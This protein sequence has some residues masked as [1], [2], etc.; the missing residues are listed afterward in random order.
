MIEL[1]K[2]IKLSNIQNLFFEIG[3][4]LNTIEPEIRF[5]RRLSL[6]CFF[7]TTGVNA[8]ASESSEELLIHNDRINNPDYILQHPNGYYKYL[9][10]IDWDSPILSRDEF[11]I[12]NVYPE[13]I[14]LTMKSYFSHPAL[15]ELIFSDDVDT[16]C[17]DLIRETFFQIHYFKE[18]TSNGITTTTMSLQDWLKKDFYVDKDR[19]IEEYIALIIMGH[20]IMPNFEKKNYEFVKCTWQ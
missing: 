19:L 20:H 17:I 3:F 10:I 1:E 15:S 12:F 13:A 7:H 9:K 5:N 2:M 14:V 16:E 18:K 11:E 4:V 6:N 8:L